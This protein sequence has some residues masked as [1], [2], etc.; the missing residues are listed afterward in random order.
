MQN[1]LLDEQTAELV[2]IDLGMYTINYS[3][4]IYF[5]FISGIKIPNSFF[6]RCCFRTGQDPSYP[7]DCTFPAYKRYSRWDGHHR[8]RG[9]FQEVTYA[10]YNGVSFL[11]ISKQQGLGS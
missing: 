4:F 11:S 3:D 9:S 6:V 8:C 5:A 1:I 2:H 7:R 10:L